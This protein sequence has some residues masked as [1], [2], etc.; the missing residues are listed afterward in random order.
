MPKT[1]ETIFFGGGCFWCM[2]AV[3]Q[4]LRGV[5]SVAS[6][7]AGG[8]MLNP[9]YENVSNGDT[10]HIETIKVEFDLSLVKLDDLLAVFFTSHDPTTLNRQGHDVGTQY[11]SAII[12]TSPEQ[13]ITIEKFINRLVAEQTFAQPIVTELIPFSDFF[14]AEDYH[15][16]YYRSNPDQPYCQTVISPKIS[17]LRQQYTHL[18][19]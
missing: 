2:E 18:L 16:N 14:P 9:S 17:K 10:G 1:T 13:K 12:Y 11:R 8:S 7:Y 15:Q 6:G 4:M 19:K 3:F 5:E